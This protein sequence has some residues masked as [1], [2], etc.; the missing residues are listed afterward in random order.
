MFEMFTDRSRRVI[1]HS[2]EE[3]EKLMQPFIDT[4]HILLGLLKEK[5][6]T[7]AEIF[8]KRGINLN[9][10][11]KDIKN[12]SEGR[13]NLLIK[14]SLPFGPL[15]RRA[16]EFS[17]EECRFLGG[18]YVNPEHLLLGLLREERGKA[19]SILKRLGFE[20]NAMRD[21]VKSLS[22]NQNKTSKSATPTIDEFGKDLTELA[23]NSKLDPVIGRFDEIERLIQILCRRIKNNAILIGEP[24]VGKTAIV[25]GLAQKMISD[26]IP[27]LL[28]NKRLISLDLGVLVAGTKYRGQFEERMKNIIKEI[29]A[30]K[31]IIIFIDEIHTI[32]GAGA[33]EG[34]IDASNMLKPALSRG[35]IQCI[36]A[37]TLSEYRKHFEKDG[38]LDRRFQT[39]MINQPTEKETVEILQGLKR[40]Y[41]DFHRVLIPDEVIKETVYLTERYA[42]NRY[43]PDKSIDVIDEASSKLKLKHNTIPQEITE[44]TKSIENLKAE[45]QNYVSVGKMSNSDR[46]LNKIQELGEIKKT[47]YS[48]WKKQISDEWPTLSL[49]DVM[50]VVSKST[51]IP[52]QKLATDELEKI[53]NIENKLKE[54][55]IGQDEP[56]IEVSKSIKRSF[57][58]L[59]NP[60]KPIGSFIFLGP[61]GVGKTELAKR[62]AEHIFG[63]TSALIRIDMSEFMDKFNV[64]KLVG[65]PPGY[66]GYD[67]GGTLTEKVRRQPYS[68][69]LFDEVEKAH[70][71][72]LNILLQILDEGMVTDSSGNNINFKNTIIVLTS[73]LGTKLSLTTKAM[74]FKFEDIHNNE[75]DYSTFKENAFKELK[76]KFSPE[77]LN[78]LDNIIVFKPLGKKELFE[79]IDL[80][81]EEINNRLSKMKKRLHIVNDDVKE[82]LLSKDYNY[83]YGARPIKRLMQQW[84]E[85]PLS[86]LF[87]KGKFKHRKNIKILKGENK[88][89]FK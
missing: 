2:R 76:D 49:E 4:E 42:T 22:R 71:E 74:G 26:D 21:E 43:Q 89:V 60:D 47:K 46:Y 72:V 80:Q 65:A 81:L 50:D 29:E 12:I 28:K 6:G 57:A 15:A 32:V 61:T 5:T 54:F 34:S 83:L 48:E 9:V 7:V 56:V 88:L 55:I 82:F 35:S 39:L 37:T 11:I 8:I 66:V 16:L 38:A 25:E 63:S 67:E 23:K 27:E 10:L 78:R 24:G 31:N 41:E 33:A 13:Q 87:I 69:I 45:M 40:Y 52:V 70:P 77:F 59:G 30:D 19:F 68:V 53:A 14:G 17:M 3:A 79:I 84:I 1:L 62:I 58:G 86:D 85:D 64:S 36:G 51:G 75:I 44:L 18:K 20:L 73:N